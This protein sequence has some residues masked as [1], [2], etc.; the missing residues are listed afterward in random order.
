MYEN[1]TEGMGFHELLVALPVGVRSSIEGVA[2]RALQQAHVEI[3][4]EEA[5]GSYSRLIGAE[6]LQGI[7]VIVEAQAT[8]R[9]LYNAHFGIT[10]V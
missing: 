10:E 2:Q 7:P 1:Q 3:D 6:A 5:P 4:S 9:K 8:M